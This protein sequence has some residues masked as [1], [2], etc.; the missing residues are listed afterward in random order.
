MANEQESRSDAIPR[1]PDEDDLA[2]AEDPHYVLLSRVLHGLRHLPRASERSDA[3][4]R[5]HAPQ[6]SA[7]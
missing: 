1:W 3:V 2:L 5:G 7:A 6:L 4:A